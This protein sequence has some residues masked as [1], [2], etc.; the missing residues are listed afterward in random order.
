MLS[1]LFRVGISRRSGSILLL[2]A[3][4]LSLRPDDLSACPM[5]VGSFAW[6]VYGLADVVLR[7]E[8]VGYHYDGS[9]ET[10]FFDLGHLRGLDGTL[11]DDDVVIRQVPW[12]TPDGQVPPRGWV[13]KSVI[14]GLT[15]RL[16]KR[17]NPNFQLLDAGCGQSYILDDT[18]ENLRRVQDGVKLVKRFKNI[19]LL[20]L[21]EGD[22]P[23]IRSEVDKILGSRCQLG[24]C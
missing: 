3:S 21:F 23:A 7:A 11:F 6:G 8:I 1:A 9:G 20:E 19:T 5:A 22:R 2:C 10:A 16:D 14:V 13:Q 17:A 12:S 4:L 24:F 15:L 18:A